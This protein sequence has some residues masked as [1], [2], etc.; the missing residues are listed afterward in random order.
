MHSLRRRMASLLSVSREST[1]LLST[2]PQYGQFT[3]PRSRMSQTDRF[4]PYQRTGAGRPPVDIADRIQHIVYWRSLHP[5]YRRCNPWVD[6]CAVLA[7][8]TC[9]GFV[10]PERLQRIRTGSFSSRGLDSPAAAGHNPIVDELLLVVEDDP[11]LREVIRLGMEGEGYRVEAVED[12]PSALTAFAAC[13]PD[14]VLL[15]I[16]LPGLDGFAVCKELRKT[17]LVPIIMLTARSST[18]DV[19][20]G[21]EA[22]A[23]DYVTKPFEFPELN[24]RVRSVMRRAATRPSATDP[25]PADKGA[26]GDTYRTAD[27]ETTAGRFQPAGGRSKV[28]APP[29]TLGSLTI[30]P[31]GYRV[32]RN[33]KEIPLTVTEFRLLYELAR[34]AGQVLTRDQLL[35]LVWGYTFLG[36]SRLVDVHVQRLRAKIEEDPGNPAL[37][38]T[39]R[40]VGYRADGPNSVP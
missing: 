28:S 15:D 4:G 23:D 38:V 12:G 26:V 39:V 33:D 13:Q 14:L 21:L 16:M 11:S 3:T 17:S 31:A 36:D 27:P 24:A 19:V 2:K 9:P 20:V 7:R 5:I 34:H 25:A 6:F 10:R 35:E 18:V 22:G 29:I 32:L 37:I 30:D 8:K 40:G 1:T